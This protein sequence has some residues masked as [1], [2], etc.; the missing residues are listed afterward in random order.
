PE[1]AQLAYAV[2]AEHGR[3]PTVFDPTAGD[4]ALLQAFPRELRF[5]VEIDPDQVTAGDYTAITGDIQRVYPLL[6]L[7]GVEFGALVLN[8]P[9]ELDWTAPDG[10]R[11]NSAVLCRRYALGL[12]GRGGQ[13]MLIC[14]RDRFWRE[15]A[16]EARSVW[17]VI[18]AADLFEGVELAC[19]LAFFCAPDNHRG[20]DPLRLEASRAELPGLAAEVRA[21][22][23]ERCGYISAGAQGTDELAQ[24]FRSIEIEHKRRLEQSRRGSRGRF[25]LS[26]KGDRVAFHASAFAK[27]AL[28]R[29][30]LLRLA[31]QLHGKSVHYFALNLREWRRISD[32]GEDGALVIE[33]RMPERVEA[34]VRGAV[35]DATPLY[36]VK[37]Q[38]RLGFL[39]DLER[40]KC[41][42][43]DPERGFVAG[44]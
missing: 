39:E 24:T 40:I 6:K 5:G 18:E 42:R 25:D 31:E 1:A 14:G 3:V 28:A 21:A 37:P 13:A 43:D 33:P 2:F 30:R 16:P 9:F 32:A 29:R 11:V 44:E 38:M 17:C 35:R 36:A 23:G 12:M 19:V 8:P 41:V 22:R 7:A 20:G 26:L 4:G 34:V 10:S 27:V 15:L